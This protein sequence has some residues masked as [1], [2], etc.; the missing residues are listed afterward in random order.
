MG[1]WDNGEDRARID[2]WLE[3]NASLQASLGTDST[4]EERYRVER[5]WKDVLVPKIRDVD[6]EFAER[7]E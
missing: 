3:L 1:Y 6:A 2:A 4:D 5:M 7:V